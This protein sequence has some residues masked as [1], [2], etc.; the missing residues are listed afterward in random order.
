MDN[1]PNAENRSDVLGRYRRTLEQRARPVRATIAVV[2]DNVVNLRLIN[3]MLRRAGYRVL[4]SRDAEEAI[5]QIRAHLPDL[6]LMDIR[7]SGLDGL[8]ATRRLKNDAKTSNIPVI[9]VTAHAMPGDREKAMA[10]GCDGYTTK[11]IRYQELLCLIEETLSGH[12]NA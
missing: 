11:P 8:G 1:K 10:A 3:E 6:V 4:S 7:M 5:A 9:A 2:E 12:D